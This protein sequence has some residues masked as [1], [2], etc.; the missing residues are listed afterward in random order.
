MCMWSGSHSGGVCLQ[1]VVEE[2]S[3]WCIISFWH[4]QG[5]LRIIPR[6]GR[7]PDPSTPLWYPEGFWPRNAAILF[8]LLSYQPSTLVNHI[9]LPFPNFQQHNHSIASV[10]DT[11]ENSKCSTPLQSY[12]HNDLQIQLVKV[13][14]KP[15]FQKFHSFLRYLPNTLVQKLSSRTLPDNT[16]HNYALVGGK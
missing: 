12:T 2:P 15:S 16:I 11:E 5:I 1:S 7:R 9:R 6:R 4:A 8:I 10:K 13:L 3:T 14:A